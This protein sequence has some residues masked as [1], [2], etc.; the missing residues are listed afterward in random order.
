MAVVYSLLVPVFCFLLRPLVTPLVSG[1]SLTKLQLV[2]VFKCC[3]TRTDVPAKCLQ[4]QQQ[5]QRRGGTNNSF[6]IS[7]RRIS[8]PHLLRAIY[9][10]STQHSTAKALLSATTTRR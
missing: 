7:T 9:I 5:Q 10:Q 3:R 6:A 2:R 4:Q 1:C 8:L